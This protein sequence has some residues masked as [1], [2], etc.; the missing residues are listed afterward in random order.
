MKTGRRDYLKAAGLVGLGL[1]G[2]SVAASSPAAAA[3]GEMFSLDSETLLN[4]GTWAFKLDD[5][6]HTLNHAFHG[7]GFWHQDEIYQ[8]KPDTYAGTDELR[9]LVSLDMSKEA[10]SGLLKH[11]RFDRFNKTYGPGER[12]VPVSWL[13]EYNGGRVFYSNLGHRNETFW[14]PEILRHFLD[15]IQYALGDLEAD[16]T[17]T[18]QAGSR[19][20]ALAPA[21]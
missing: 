15:G 13:R 19:K 7:K 12:E 10:V 16:A 17:P 1:P 8:Y 4:G 21:R 5:P 6:G 2:A 11:P 18:D 3:T 20:P 9:I 14:H